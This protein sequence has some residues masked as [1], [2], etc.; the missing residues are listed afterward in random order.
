MPTAGLDTSSG[1]FVQPVGRAPARVVVGR[2]LAT[3]AKPVEG[4]GAHVLLR[5]AGRTLFAIVY[6]LVLGE[7]FLRYVA[8]VPLFPRH[9]CETSYGIRGNEPNAHYWHISQDVCIEFRTNSKGVRADREIPYAKPVGVRRIVVLGDSFGMGYEVSLEDAFTTRLERALNAA[10]V[11]CEVVNLSVSGHGNAEE[12]ILL[13]EEGLRYQPD[14]VLVAWNAG[15]LGDNVRSELFRLEGGHLV[16]NSTTYLPGI[17]LKRKLDRTVVYPWIAE[18]SM[19][20]AWLRETI[21]RNARAVLAQ[22][23]GRA[24]HGG[25]SAAADLQAEVPG[26][27][28][29][30]TVALLNEMEAVARAQGAP[31]V[32]LDIPGRRTR[33]E[34]ISRFP[35]SE[36]LSPSIR[37]WSPMSEFQKRRGQL[38]YSEHSQRHLTPLGCRIIGEGLASVIV[39]EH[40]WAEPA[41]N[42]ARAPR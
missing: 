4:A 7:M 35:D 22:C 19:L 37:V 18:Y 30:L 23:R 27:W 40:L 3:D 25:E 28:Q 31:L 42:L 32:V 2:S 36:R 39:Q 9:V 6:V 26:A 8:P 21:T 20:H 24:L 11:R 34:F 10:G 41:D 15:D 38:L 33:T 16:R 12:L 13:R 17:D 5:R 14:L 1:V 29:E